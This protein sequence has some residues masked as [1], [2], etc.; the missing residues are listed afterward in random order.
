MFKRSLPHY[1]WRSHTNRE[2]YSNYELLIKRV[3]EHVDKYNSLFEQFD[4]PAKLL[5]VESIREHKK[6]YPQSFVI[7]LR[8]LKYDKITTRA[9]IVYENR[10]RKLDFTHSFD[11]ELIDEEKA[12]RN[13]DRPYNTYTRYYKTVFKGKVRT[14]K[15]MIERRSPNG[16]IFNSKYKLCRYDRLPA[17]EAYVVLTEYS[18]YIKDLTRV[19]GDEILPII[20]NAYRESV[21]ITPVI[22]ITKTNDKKNPWSIFTRINGVANKIGSYAT[23][24]A[25]LLGLTILTQALYRKSHGDMYPLL[26]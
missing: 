15:K 9:E 20:G 26:E 3:N 22:G 8:I 4:I 21:T 24:S 25:A 23:A 17:L 7:D 5:V 12:N 19:L 16:P 11:Y 18:N 6:S 10:V 2:D 1:Y 13:P 14:R